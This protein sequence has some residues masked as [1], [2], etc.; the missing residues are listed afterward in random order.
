MKKNR[1][2]K[3]AD[4]IFG[5]RMEETSPYWSRLSNFDPFI[6]GTDA[7]LL[8]SL[9]VVDEI[10]EPTISYTFDTRP[11]EG[12]T[13]ISYQKTESNQ[14]YFCI[15]LTGNH[16][17]CAR[18]IASEDFTQSSIEI[19]DARLGAFAINSALMMLYSFTAARCQTLLIHASTVINDGLAY[20]FLGKSGTG[21]STHSHLWLE[22]IEGSELLND[23]NPVIRVHDDGRIMAYGSPWS[24]KTPCYKNMSAPVGA[25][26]HIQQFPENM[27]TRLDDFNA[28][29][30]LYSSCSRFRVIKEIADGQHRAMESIISRH[31]CY[32]LRCRPDKDA[33][34]TCSSYLRKGNL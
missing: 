19:V 34:V 10:P 29:S 4:H 12:H 27:I 14:W 17:V 1:H 31:L 25:L 33:A 18:M 22:H 16:P 5:I 9:E 13:Y 11:V 32:L 23:D 26:V 3:V 24:G 20:L 15:S 8:F 7:P 28:Y 21:K 30:S 6:C 2:C